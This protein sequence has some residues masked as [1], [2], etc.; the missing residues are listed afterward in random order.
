MSLYLVTGGAG[1]IGSH[2]AHRFVQNGEKVRIL[3][4]FST[5]RRENLEDIAGAVEVVEGDIRDGGTVRS[6]VRGADFI[7]HQAA[8]ASVP[9]SIEDPIS[10]N[11]VNIGG[12]LNLLVAAREEGVAR[13]VFASSSSVYGDSESP[14]K[15]ETDPLAP[16]SPYA[17][18]KQ[19]GEMYG[20]VFHSL[21]GLPFVALRYFNV[22]GPNQDENSPYAAVIPIFVDRMLQGKRPVIYGDGTQSRDFTYISNV[23][24]ANVL[25]LSRDEAVGTVMNVACG[26]SYDLNYLVKALNQS[27]G[28]E[29]EPVYDPPRPGD[30]LHSRADISRAKELLRFTPRTSFEDGMEQTVRWYQ[31]RFSAGRG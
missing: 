2:L 1:F 6:A 8:L 14:A 31:E 25:A 7:V 27:L 5:G 29:M 30:V 23:V 10:T 15:K 18:S 21:H 22:F 19:V 9:R 20:L 24:D 16:L 13:F 17:V 3:D 26:D 28:L 12:T 4:D 11:D